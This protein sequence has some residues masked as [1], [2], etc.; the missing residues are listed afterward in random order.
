WFPYSLLFRFILLVFV[1][2]LIFV[3]CLLLIA[4]ALGLRLVA[5]RFL[6]PIPIAIS[7]V[8]I[9]A[10]RFA[11]FFATDFRRRLHH[12]LLAIRDAA[13]IT[14][15][16]VICLS[17]FFRAATIAVAIVTAAAVGAVTAG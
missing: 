16:A 9:D 3:L 11:I 5:A 17:R 12:A 4:I 1:F 2:V 13:M 14:P 7:Y 6:A 10:S 15:L 8:H